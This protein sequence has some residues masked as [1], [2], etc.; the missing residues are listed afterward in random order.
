MDHG[1]IA[2]PDRDRSKEEEPDHVHEM[3]VPSRCFKAE[4]LFGC[5]PA[6]YGAE[7]ADG[8]ED[9]ADGDMETMEAGGHEEGRTIDAAAERK[10]RMGI[11]EGL[12]GGEDQAEHHGE[13]EALN[14]ALRSEER[15]AGNGCVRTCR[16]R[17][18]Q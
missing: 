5:E 14:K 3:P 1:T 4:M 13:D 11:F 12:E 2:A 15:R 18:L 10:C 7:Q 6:I 8:K 16:Y 9:G 17:W